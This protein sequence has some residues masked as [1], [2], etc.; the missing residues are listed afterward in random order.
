MNTTHI[1]AVFG[2]L[3]GFL[4]AVEPPRAVRTPVTVDEVRQAIAREYPRRGLGP[5]HS[6]H[7][8]QIEL[9]VAV[10]AAAERSLRVAGMCWVVRGARLQFRMECGESGQCMPFLAYARTGDLPQTAPTT[11]DG[12]SCRAGSEMSGVSSARPATRPPARPVVRSG[13]HATVVFAG[14]RLRMSAQVTCLERGGAG[15][16]IRVRNPD[17]RTFRARV[18]GAGLLEA[19]IQN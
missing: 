14:E 19:L 1:F 2:L 4:L 3:G 13:E 9:P 18:V 8:A 17:G 11:A 15:Q 12:P 16:V 7:A 6:L 5:E 10:S